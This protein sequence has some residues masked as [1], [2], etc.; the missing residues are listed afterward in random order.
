MHE[1]RRRSERNEVSVE[2][3]LLRGD[4]IPRGCRVR[5]FS[6]NGMQLQWGADG[7][8]SDLA[9]G[10]TVRIHLSVQHSDRREM[11][12]IPAIVKRTG[13]RWVGVEFQEPQPMLPGLLERYRVVRSGPDGSPTNG[14]DNGGT[15]HDPGGAA[16]D[17][18]EM[19]RP[20]SLSSPSAGGDDV[21]TNQARMRATDVISGGRAPPKVDVG[22]STAGGG[23]PDATNARW[24]KGLLPVVLVSLLVVLPVAVSVLLLSQHVHRELNEVRSTLARLSDQL[25]ASERRS[26]R[27]AE[28]ESTLPDVIARTDRP[29]K[30]IADLTIPSSA[31]ADTGEESPEERS[32]GEKPIPAVSESK[33]VPPIGGPDQAADLQSVRGAESGWPADVQFVRG[34]EPEPP[35]DLQSVRG[36]APEPPADQPAPESASAAPVGPSWDMVL[37]SLRN[38]RSADRLLAKARSLDIPAEKHRTAPGAKGL[39]RL[40]VS[41]FASREGARAYAEE[42]KPKLGLSD[43]WIV[44][45]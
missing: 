41:G 15:A 9:E 25:D 35:A 22:S 19:L 1:E 8:R 10:D 7:W 39:W 4:K 28:P 11:L 6:P 17:P 2:A 36:P 18:G 31:P 20:N 29:Q 30:A 32:A 24:L 3:L 16:H 37:I 44:R 42:I 23:M 26:A 34:P 27:V 12:A 21:S 14:Q 5:E 45:H 33:P 40:Q 13:E 43:V 38:E